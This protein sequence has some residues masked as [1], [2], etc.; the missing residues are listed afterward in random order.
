MSLADLALVLIYAGLLVAVLIGADRA[1]KAL[2]MAPEG[3]RKIVHVALGLAVLT[4]PFVFAGPGPVVLLCVLCVGVLML[5]RRQRA[6][7]AALHDVG[8]ASLGEIYFAVSVAGLFLL[9]AVGVKAGAAAAA[10]SADPSVFFIVPIA[11]MTLAD[12]AAALA[13]T[14]YGKRIFFVE[15]GH[16]SVEGVAAFFL[17]SWLVALILLLLLTGIPRAEVVALSGF[18]AFVGASIEAE[19]WGGLDNLFVPFGAYLI[20]IG[21]APAGLGTIL[22]YTLGYATAVVV[23][24]RIARARDVAQQ[25][26]RAAI[27]LV[28]VFLM[29]FGALNTMLLATAVGMTLAANRIAPPAEKHAD[30]HT[31]FAV[32]AIGLIWLVAGNAVG[33][34]FIL[35]FSISVAIYGAAM[36]A[37]ALHRRRWAV[38]LAVAAIGTVLVVR[39]HLDAA[40]TAPAHM[41]PGLA[42]V[43]AVPVLCL[44]WPGLFA[45]RR[46]LKVTLAALGFSGVSAAVMGA[47]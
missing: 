32:V 3:R 35:F 1:G 13:G 22:L 4:L 17:V 37:I 34:D 44:G 40:E 41:L 27:L 10:I 16:K 11:I 25:P 31:V 12:T 6:L 19:S 20:L 23:S 14:E 9:Q 36:A 28:A 30:L 5:A 21:L 42:G 2:G 26:I 46:A 18:L 7:G 38:M 45:R 29:S 43:L 24:H 15:R 47:G 39:L 8:R 33:R